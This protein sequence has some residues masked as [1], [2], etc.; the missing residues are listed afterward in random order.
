MSGAGRGGKQP[1]TTW[2]PALTL[3][4]VAE[5]GGTTASMAAMFRRP[6]V[7]VLPLPRELVAVTDCRI[8]FLTSAAVACGQ[9]ALYSAA[10]PVTC[11][12]A[13]EVPL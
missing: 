7:D 4:Q 10:A 13:M 11:G 2:Q 6:P 3:V 9:R 12:V 1:D 8:A 5:P